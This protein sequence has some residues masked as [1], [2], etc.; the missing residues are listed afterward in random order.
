MKLVPNRN[1]MNFI[2]QANEHTLN[3]RT[4]S[5]PVTSVAGE[6]PW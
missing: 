1:H 6:V 2:W 3:K 4:K 5:S